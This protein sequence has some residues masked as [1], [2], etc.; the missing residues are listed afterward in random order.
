MNRHH[1]LMSWMGP[2]PAVPGCDCHICRPDASYDELD[3][4]TIDSVLEHGWQVVLVATGAGCCAA[5]H[6]DSPCED[7]EQGPAFGYTVGLGHRLGHPELFMSGLDHRLMHDVLNNLAR[8]VMDGRALAAGDVLEDVLCGVPV[9]VEQVADDALRETVNWSGWFHRSKPEALAI[10]WPDRRG[11]FAWQP[12]ASEVLDELQP[13]RW[14]APIEHA[15]ALT[16]D[17]AWTFPV[18]PDY[19]ALS[20]THVVEDGAA[21]LWAAREVGAAQGEVWSVHCGAYGHRDD[22]VCLAH[23]AHLVR[24]APSLRALSDLGMD[25]EAERPDTDSPW[26]TARLAD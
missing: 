24:A 18:P 19:M 22:E 10:V 1:D 8:R 13:P 11:V 14:R 7:E 5:D 9:V 23:L 16:A 26:S 6:L 12:G 25:E 21:V 15:E 3:R 20:C 4:G 2:L 17:P